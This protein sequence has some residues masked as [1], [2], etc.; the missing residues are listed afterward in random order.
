[1]KLLRKTLAIAGF[2]AAA[3]VAAPAQALTL[4]N[5]DG[6]FAW[7]GFD[8][9]Q[10]GTAYTTGFAPVAGT[11]F[12]LNFFSWAVSLNNTPVTFAPPG[13][14][15]DANGVL[16]GGKSY[17]YTVVAQ[18][19]ETVSFCND[20]GGGLF[21]CGFQVTSGSFSVYYDLAGTAN[22]A[23]GSNGTG[24]AD[25]ILLIS[26]VFGN[27]FGG[28]FTGDG[29]N[30]TG[31]S[32][33]QGVITYTNTTYIDPELLG[34]TV[35]TLLQLGNETTNWVNPGGFNGVAFN[36]GN[37]VFQADGNQNF[38]PRVVPE[39]GSLALLASALVVGSL[40]SR[41]RAK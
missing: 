15:I 25:G 37:I 29:T 30:G 12:T 11:N 33:L 19:N 32:T 10:G 5:T 2:A 21:N 23:A 27:Q 34:T 1:M 9:A 31:N 6:T 7:T 4:T 41:R 26:G 14:D 17:E 13:L 38:T 35:S 16:D 20:I 8:W 3:V 24:F 22:A 36:E 28:T 39:P 40:V 18:L